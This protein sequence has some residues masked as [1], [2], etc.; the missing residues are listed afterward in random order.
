[1]HR[2]QRALGPPWLHDFVSH[3]G[4]A[5][6]EAQQGLLQQRAVVVIDPVAEEAVGDAEDQLAV[7][8][9]DRLHPLEPGQ[10]VALAV[11]AEHAQGACPEVLST[12][13]A[14]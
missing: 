2:G 9:G 14:G 11:L 8:Q 3:A 10:R 7:A 1:M 4:G 6:H 12:R 13:S 5:S